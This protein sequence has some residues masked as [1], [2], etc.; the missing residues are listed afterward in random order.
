[1][2]TRLPKLSTADLHGL[3]LA[4]SGGTLAPGSSS[5][6]KPLLVC[7]PPPWSAQLRVYIYNISNTPG[8][9]HPDE[10]KIQMKLPG[11]EEAAS[12]DFTPPYITILAGARSDLGAIVLWDA[13]LFSEFT[14]N[15]SI[16][17][18]GEDL[19]RGL[20]EGIHTSRRQ[21]GQGLRTEEVVICREDH[22]PQAL[23]LRLELTMRRQIDEVSP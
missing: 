11:V 13:E 1:M 18:R 17:V 8:G 4:K 7:M 19:Y 22:L 20:R 23:R 9:R 2:A 3:F 15:R 16:Y 14:P 5:L 12:L 21:V 6:V 10:H